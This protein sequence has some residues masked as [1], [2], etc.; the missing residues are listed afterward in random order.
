MQLSPYDMVCNASI[1]TYSLNHFVHRTCTN[2]KCSNPSSPLP[3]SGC[4]IHHCNTL[5][6]HQ[7]LTHLHAFWHPL[8]F[9]IFPLYWILLLGNHPT[10]SLHCCSTK[11]GEQG[12]TQLS[13]QYS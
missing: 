7:C 5:W 9:Q 12:E 13:V 8:A 4:L 3:A 1:R 10:T 11:H 6:G 2:M